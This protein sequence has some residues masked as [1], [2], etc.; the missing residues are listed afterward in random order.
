MDFFTLQFLSDPH[1][2]ISLLTLTALEIVLGIDNVVFISIIAGKLPLD[3]QPAARKLGLGA[4]LV[5]R[6]LLLASIAWIIGLTTPIFSI[7]WIDHTVSWRDVI[8]L[9]GGMFLLGK[10]TW[11]IH[12]TIEG[13]EDD[14][15]DGTTGPSFAAVVGQIIV[16][17]VV[18]SIDSVVTA[19]GMAEHLPV[20]IAAV[21]IAMLIMLWSSGPVARF[22][23]DH[24]TTKM[25][26]LSFLLLVGMSLVADGMHFHIPRGYLY[27]AIAFSIVVEA[28]NLAVQRRRRG[29]RA[30]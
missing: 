11:E 25:L 13:E 16:L 19:V 7:P 6:I 15:G 23:H 14:A 4:A 29:R 22:I 5:L 28:L 12:E 27:F 21:V 26:A 8:L 3:R 9:A 2:W 17:D 24:P 30:A 18:F 10:G 20:M 1:V